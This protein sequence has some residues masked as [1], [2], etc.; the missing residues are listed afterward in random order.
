MQ[1]RHNLL[2]ILPH[3]CA[4]RKGSRR[5]FIIFQCEAIWRIAFS[6]AL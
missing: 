4:G 3:S 1:D 5:L 2:A 6:I